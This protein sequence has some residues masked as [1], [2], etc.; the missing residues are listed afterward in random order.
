MHDLKDDYYVYDEKR[1]C[2]VG[3]HKKQEFRLGNDIKVRV[4]RTDSE[5]RTIDFEPVS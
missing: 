2:L 5:R 3:R 1:H 4:V